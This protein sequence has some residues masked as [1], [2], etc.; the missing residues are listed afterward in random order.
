[1]PSDKRNRKPGG[2]RPTAKRRLA[3]GKMLGKVGPKNKREQLK[4]LEFPRFQLEWHQSDPLWCPTDRDRK[5]DELVIC[6]EKISRERQQ[7]AIQS[8][9]E[10]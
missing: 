5:A 2:P 3:H 9:M 6:R 1:M 8:I 4:K 10:I 7:W